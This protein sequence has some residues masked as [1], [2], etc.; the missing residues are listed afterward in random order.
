M[1]H[2]I[3][4]A[5]PSLL[6]IPRF[7]HSVHSATA[8]NKSWPRLEEA[9][10]GLGARM[11]ELCCYR[12]HNSKRETKLIKIV[13]ECYALAHLQSMCHLH[14]AG[15]NCT[16]TACTNKTAASPMCGCVLFPSAFGVMV[17]RWR[18]GRDSWH[19]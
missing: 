18:V 8:E 15:T 16:G 7:T 13:Q 19:S 3:V 9:G 1:K 4:T 10:Y 11:L 12:E 2:F 14:R 17:V 6:S 5:H